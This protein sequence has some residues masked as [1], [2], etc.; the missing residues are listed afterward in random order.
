MKYLELSSLLDRLQTLPGMPQEAH[1][2]LNKIREALTSG[3]TVLLVVEG[4]VNHS[5]LC[6]APLP[7]RVLSLDYDVEGLEPD[8]LISVP[9]G[10][11]FIDQPAYLSHLSVDDDDGFIAALEKI[12]ES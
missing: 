7:V 11:G 8:Q 5:T 1:A 6:R 2:D 10:A 9:Q 12:E 4:G 3:V